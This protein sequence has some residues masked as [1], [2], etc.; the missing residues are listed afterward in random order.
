LKVR[1]RTQPAKGAQQPQIGIASFG[2]RKKL[3]EAIAALG[4]APAAAPAATPVMPAPISAA[5]A[6]PQISAAP[7]AAGERR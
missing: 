3:L 2:H 4:N 6:P 1:G 5:V 7:E